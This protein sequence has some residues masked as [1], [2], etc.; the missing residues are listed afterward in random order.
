[1]AN[2]NQPLYIYI[3]TIN[4]HIRSG[5]FKRRTDEHTGKKYPFFEIPMHINSAFFDERKIVKVACGCY[6]T[7]AVSENGKVFAWGEGPSFRVFFTRD[8]IFI[9]YM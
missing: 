7:L 4:I 8:I 1:M 2:L 6:F 5:F 9:I 3:I